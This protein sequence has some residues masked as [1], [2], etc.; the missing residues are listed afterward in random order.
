MS[1]GLTRSRIVE[2]LQEGEALAAGQG[3]QLV[4]AYM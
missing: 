2:G 3:C 1:S 4:P